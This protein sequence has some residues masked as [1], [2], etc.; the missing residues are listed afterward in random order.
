MVIM[1]SKENDTGIKKHNKPNR[2]LYSV[3][4]IIIVALIVAFIYVYRLMTNELNQIRESELVGKETICRLSFDKEYSKQ[5]EL[6]VLRN[7]RLVGDYDYCS[8]YSD[9]YLVSIDRCGWRTTELQNTYLYRLAKLY[10]ENHP[11]LTLCHA[12]LCPVTGVTCSEGRSPS[13]TTTNILEEGVDE[14]DSIK[15]DGKYIYEIREDRVVIFQAWPPEEFKIVAEIPATPMK[16]LEKPFDMMWKEYSCMTP[17]SSYVH[18]DGLSFIPHALFLADNRL[19]VIDD[20]YYM[21]DKKLINMSDL[22]GWWF[23]SNSFDENDSA[24]IAIRVFDISNHENPVL[25]HQSQLDG[26]LM[27]SRLIDGSLHL[28]MSHRHTT[29]AETE[30]DGEIIKIDPS[31]ILYANSFPLLNPD[32]YCSY[33]RP[34]VDENKNNPDDEVDNED[35]D[36]DDD[37]V[38]DV[39]D[40]EVDDDNMPLLNNNMPETKKD[41]GECECE[42]RIGLHISYIF[43]KFKQNFKLTL[44][45]CD[46]NENC[47]LVLPNGSVRS[48]M[49]TTSPIT[50]VDINGKDFEKVDIQGVLIDSNNNAVY[51]SKNNLYLAGKLN[52]DRTVIHQFN[53][54]HG[55]SEYVGSGSVEGS[56]D[57]SFW[58]SEYDHHL[59]IVSRTDSERTWSEN[60]SST[61]NILEIDKPVLKK[62]SRLDNLG[63]EEQV[64]AVRMIQD[65]AYI[66][67]FRNTDPLYAVDLSVPSKPNLIGELKIDGY[68]TYIHPLDKDHLLT[69]GKINSNVHLQIFDVSEFSKPKR[70]HHQVLEITDSN[71]LSDHHAFIFHQDSGLLIIDSGNSD[72]IFRYNEK[73]FS[74]FLKGYIESKYIV[75]RVDIKNGFELLGTFMPKYSG[76]MSS[77]ISKYGLSSYV[78]FMHKN[79]LLYFKNEENFNE[80]GYIYTFTPDVIQ[81]NDAN[82]PENLIKSILEENR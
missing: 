60:S 50:I 69:I 17:S 6:L 72:D 15:N 3:L 25:I 44:P 30:I 43:E 16:K 48:D 73:N 62:I 24:G 46:Y 65:R 64:Y 18:V 37:E 5:D 56:I 57:D 53:L 26:N 67:T 76:K 79:S 32:E 68:S 1:M 33:L 71:A 75:Y 27:S 51:F 78:L 41:N 77:M 31:G 28:V 11:L 34:H 74:E 82:H 61:L 52:D 39:V 40:D 59:R 45:Y 21:N 80:G 81:V 63:K 38:D 22:G 47:R 35:D 8:M 13:Y 12:I 66:V 70:I 4:I 55:R 54:N 29:M 36:E 2:V 58:M 7:Y 42:E 23:Y 10:T 19:I 20:V 9:T 49:P 14:E